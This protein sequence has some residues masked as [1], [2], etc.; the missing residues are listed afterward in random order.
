MFNKKKIELQAFLLVNTDLYKILRENGV[1]R[2]GNMLLDSKEIKIKVLDFYNPAVQGLRTKNLT[3]EVVN[4]QMRMRH[5]G[6]IGLQDG[7]DTYNYLSKKKTDSEVIMF[8]WYSGYT[9][10][11]INLMKSIVFSME[12]YDQRIFRTPKITFHHNDKI[13]KLDYETKQ[14]KFIGELKEMKE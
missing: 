6:W 9:E 14:V 12:I 7:V 10:D 1:I 4:M 2:A 11:Q 5:T 3:G 13:Y 8:F